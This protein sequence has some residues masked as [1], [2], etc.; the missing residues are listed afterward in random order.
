[1]ETRDAV[2]EPW[3]LMLEKEGIKRNAIWKDI[4]GEKG[5]FIEGWKYEIAAYRLDK[6]L[7]LNMIPPTVEK[8]F[9]GKSGSCQ[10]WITSKMDVRTKVQKNVPVPQDKTKSFQRA[11]YIQQAFDNLIGNI[12]RHMGNVLITEDWRAILID[13]SR[14][15]QTEDKY[16]QELLFRDLSED[17]DF[18]MK[19]LPQAFVE[20]IKVLDFDLVEQIVGEY[21]TKEEIKALLGRK[22]LLLEYI[23]SRIKRYGEKAVLY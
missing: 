22:K 20:K 18:I 21:L 13:H 9:R 3:K 8:K 23:D 11:G 2:T 17:Q 1:M 14:A 5:G 19:E 12:D 15:F 16:N 6:F 7:E 4:Q 10:L